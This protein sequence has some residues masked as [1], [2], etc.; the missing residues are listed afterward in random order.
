MN[1]LKTLYLIKINKM[2]FNKIQ[3]NFKLIKMIYIINKMISKTFQIII[4]MIKYKV[5]IL[6]NYK[7]YLKKNMQ[8]N[9]IFLNK[10]YSKVLSH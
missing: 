5:K 10:Y 1:I 6:K 8:I 3:N 4:L 2:N 9:L 7:K